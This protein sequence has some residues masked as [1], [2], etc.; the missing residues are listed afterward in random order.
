MSFS[1]TGARRSSKRLHNLP[2]Y[3]QQ[4]SEHVCHFGVD[5]LNHNVLSLSTATKS[6]IYT[7]EERCTAYTSCAVN[8]KLSSKAETD[9]QRKGVHSCPV[10]TRAAHGV[11]PLSQYAAFL[12]ARP[13]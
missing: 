6:Y 8:S 4:Q 5:V 12:R 13:E 9:R 2:S 10:K 7:A 3:L 1:R 11:R